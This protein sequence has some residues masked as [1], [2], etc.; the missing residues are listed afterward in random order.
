MSLKFL[1]E[2]LLLSSTPALTAP[3][4]LLCTEVGGQYIQEGAS[5]LEYSGTSKIEHPICPLIDYINLRYDNSIADCHPMHLASSEAE[6]Y[7]A[8]SVEFDWN[9]NEA[10]VINGINNPDFFTVEE[11][12][13]QYLLLRKRRPNTPQTYREGPYEEFTMMIDKRS[14][15][16]SLT[17]IEDRTNSERVVITTMTKGFCKETN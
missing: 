2:A 7:D 17:Q 15:T 6:D 13:Q 11:A 16:F 8:M 5:I 10:L 1:L 3:T 12:E 14:L 4:K 9:T